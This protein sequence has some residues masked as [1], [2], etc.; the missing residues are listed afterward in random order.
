MGSVLGSYA[1]LREVIYNAC[2]VAVLSARMV[3]AMLCSNGSMKF[4]F[5]ALWYWFL[6]QLIMDTH[7]VSTSASTLIFFFNNAPSL[8]GDG[9][10]LR[11]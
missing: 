7:G 9:P 6:F 8:S 1:Y 10:L 4:I 2:S 11:R 5:L 3:Q